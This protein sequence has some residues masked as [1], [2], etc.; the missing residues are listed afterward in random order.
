MVVSGFVVFTPDRTL[1]QPWRSLLDIPCWSLRMDGWIHQIYTVI[2]L[3]DDSCSRHFLLIMFILAF[4]G[5]DWL[6][7]QACGSIH[8]L[9][10]IISCS[11]DGLMV[12][13]ED[14]AR[15]FLGRVGR[16]HVPYRP[17]RP[18]LGRLVSL[19]LFF[20]LTFS[21][22]LTSFASSQTIQ[23]DPASPGSRYQLTPIAQHPEWLMVSPIHNKLS[24]PMH[25]A[26]S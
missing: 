10:M 23:R 19:C 22:F 13:F 24:S 8:L 3:C 20:F 5:C 1:H 17:Y 9:A 2:I 12:R 4:Q 15:L 21:F 26:R 25:H 6:E 14:H 18:I 7:Q 16:G 11:G